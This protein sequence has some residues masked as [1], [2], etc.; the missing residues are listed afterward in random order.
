MN[1]NSNKKSI[2]TVSTFFFAYFSLLLDSIQVFA[3][4]KIFK[5]ITKL[6]LLS[7]FAT[8]VKLRKFR[9]AT[10]SGNFKVVENLREF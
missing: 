9:V 10:H 2:R 8:R 1:E 4:L 3:A 6:E 7:V 5:G